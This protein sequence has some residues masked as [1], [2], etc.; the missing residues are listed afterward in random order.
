MR[1]ELHGCRAWAHGNPQ[2]VTTSLRDHYVTLDRWLK[3]GNEDDDETMRVICLLMAPSN[4]H[5][6]GQC[7]IVSR[8]S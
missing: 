8:L 3:D 2:H 7:H 6:I 4:G 5:N 1:M